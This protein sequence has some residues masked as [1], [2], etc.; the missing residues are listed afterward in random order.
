MG[1]NRNE[2]T[3]SILA[4]IQKHEIFLFGLTFFHDTVPSCVKY[5]ISRQPGTRSF[6]NC[7]IEQDV[8]DHGGEGRKHRRKN[9][10]ADE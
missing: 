1:N 5:E 7:G 6:L 9:G 10:P 2:V 3:S 4:F 8:E